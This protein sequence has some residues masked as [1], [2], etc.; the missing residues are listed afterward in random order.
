MRAIKWI[1][2]HTQTLLDCTGA[3]PKKL[4][5]HAAEYLADIHN[6]SADESI[7]WEIPTMLR[8]S[9]TLEIS[10]YLQ[11]MFYEPIFYHDPMETYPISKEKAGYW[12]GVAHHVGDNL[13]Y[14]ILTADSSRIL[15]C[16]IV[17]PTNPCLHPSKRVPF[18]PS[19]LLPHSPSYPLP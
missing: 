11:F 8:H 2:M 1:K 15:T 19:P 18:T 16:S 10:A 12:V 13:T 9:E 7:R 17:R 5:L 6:V 4:C 14:K 3:P